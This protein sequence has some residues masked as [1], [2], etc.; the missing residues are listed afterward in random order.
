MGADDPPRAAVPSPWRTI[1]FSPRIT[2]RQ[3]N[4]ADVRP[5][6][7]PVMVL[8]VPVLLLNFIQSIRSTPSI[9]DTPTSTVI[10][11]FSKYE[12]FN[13]VAAPFVLAFL[14]HWLG[15]IAP[16]GRLWRAVVWSHIPVAAASAFW[17]PVVLIFGRR[18]LLEA[19]TG[20]LVS[21][22]DFA[23]ELAIFWGFVL[24]VAMV[25]EAQRFSL[26]RAITCLIGLSL[27]FF[28]YMAAAIQIERFVGLR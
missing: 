4:E 11:T 12:L 10:L 22:S 14:G 15:G 7:V 18:V 8:A 20:P 21:V 9:A 16:T 23:T 13:L 17:M 2:I 25:A 1:W 6:W 28:L 3:L 26:G 27:A 5:S 19:L 24:L